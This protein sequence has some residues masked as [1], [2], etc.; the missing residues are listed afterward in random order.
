MDW[1]KIQSIRDI[2]QRIR[3]CGND[4]E[5]HRDILRDARQVLT[6]F[7]DTQGIREGL[8]ENIDAFIEGEEMAMR[9]LSD[10]QYALLEVADSLK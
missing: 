8:L 2:I 10:T 5:V 6:E 3:D 4:E 1:E 7:P 9:L